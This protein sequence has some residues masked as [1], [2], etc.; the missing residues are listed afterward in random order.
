DLK[1]RPVAEQ[2]ELEDSRSL[3]ECS[4]IVV[5]ALVEK[6]AAWHAFGLL[7][8]QHHLAAELVARHRTIVVALGSPVVLDDYPAAALRLCAYSDVEVSQEAVVAFLRGT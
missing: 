5:H 3:T 1:D 6:P 2:S 7:P 4:R 8:E